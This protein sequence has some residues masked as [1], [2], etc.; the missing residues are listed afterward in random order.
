MRITA[1][2]GCR[3]WRGARPRRRPRSGNQPGLRATTH[4]GL[5]SS[6][7]GT[8]ANAHQ[9]STIGPGGCL[10]A[11]SAMRIL[12]LSGI[13]PPDVGGPATHAPDLA[14]FLVGRG[15]EVRVVTMADGEPTERP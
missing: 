2:P 11:L 12:V 4:P 6:A 14:R 1:G 13:W 7:P 5:A 9:A 3:S 8:C 15:H 10:T